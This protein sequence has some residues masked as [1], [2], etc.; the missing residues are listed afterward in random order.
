MYRPKEIAE[1]S[2]MIYQFSE[3]VTNYQCFVYVS[4]KLTYNE[5]ERCMTLTSTMHSLFAFEELNWGVPVLHPLWASEEVKQT[6]L[7]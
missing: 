5:S 3:D 1:V 7:L 6:D 4:G 2:E